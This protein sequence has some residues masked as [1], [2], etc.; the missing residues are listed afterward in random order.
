[1]QLEL[2]HLAAPAAGFDADECPDCG[3][4]PGA[5]VRGQLEGKR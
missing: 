2:D 5:T 4:D 1:M 3:S